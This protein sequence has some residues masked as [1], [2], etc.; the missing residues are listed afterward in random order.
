MTEYKYSS[1]IL[2]FNIPL[3]THKNTEKQNPHIILD[4]I[5]KFMDII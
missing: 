1:K 2:T 5:H 3:H 4:K